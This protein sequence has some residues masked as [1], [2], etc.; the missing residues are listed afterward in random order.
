L[1]TDFVKSLEKKLTTSVEI[2]KRYGRIVGFV[3][4]TSPSRIDEEGGFVY[5]EVDPVIYFN[6]FVD[7]ASAGGYLAVVDLK[8]LQ[9]VSLEIA[10]AE[11]RDVL[12]ELDMPEMLAAT[13]T[14]EV[15]GLLTKTRIKAKPLLSCDVFTDT[16][17]SADYVIEPQSPAIKLEFLGLPTKGVFL[18]YVTVGGQ[19]FVRRQHGALSPVEGF[20]STLTSSGHNR[21]R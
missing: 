3:S 18:G 14:T 5:F 8:T 12:A 1:N 17:I 15:T 7:I 9:L 6:E 2:A 20:L 13:P 19:G 11:R 4:R 21:E 16:V 10:A